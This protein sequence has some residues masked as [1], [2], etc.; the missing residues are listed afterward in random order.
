MK[1]ESY[2]TDKVISNTKKNILIRPLPKLRDIEP[3]EKEL[4]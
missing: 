4:Y 2:E 3:L 1:T